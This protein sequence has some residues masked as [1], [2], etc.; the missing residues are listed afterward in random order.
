M[1]RTRIALAGTVAASALALTAAPSQAA[2]PKLVG[3]VGPGFT[4][5][6][7]SGGKVVRTLKPGKYALTIGDK[8]AIH[9]FHLKGPGVN[10]DSGVYRQGTKTYTITLKRGKYSFVC[11]PHAA[12]MKGSFTVK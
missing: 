11:T 12:S 4:I 7:K 2:L 3:T 9:N 1:T 5:T 8:S 6:L 10:V